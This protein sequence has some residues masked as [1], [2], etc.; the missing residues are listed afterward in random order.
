MTAITPLH[1]EISA[2][3]KKFLDALIRDGR[4]LNNLTKEAQG[5]GSVIESAFRKMAA[6]AGVSFG[7]AQ[8]K[9][10]AQEVINTRSQIQMLEQSFTVLLGSK[11]KADAMLVDIKEIALKSPL[12]LADTSSAA[13]TLLSFNIAAEKVIPTLRQLGDISMGNSDRFR[14]L[15][16]AFAQMSSAG[17]LM[18][19]DLLQMI[20]AGFNPLQVMSEKTGKSISALRDEMSKGV[21]SSEMVADAFRSATLEGGKFYNMMEKQAAGI[22]G[23]QASLGDAWMNMMNSLGEKSEGVIQEG[24]RMTTALVENYEKIGKVLVSLIATYGAY[25]AAMALN[26]IAAAKVTVAEAAHYAALVIVEKA[27]KA[28]N[29]AMKANPYVLLATVVVG[30]ASAM[31]ALH[32]GTTAEE[33]AQQRLNDELESSKQKKDSLISK[34]NELVSVINDETQTI[35]AQTRAWNDLKKTIPEAFAGMNIEDFKR[36]S[37]DEVKSRIN[38][39]LEKQDVAKLNEDIRLLEEWVSEYEKTYKTTRERITGMNDHVARLTNNSEAKANILYLKELNK[40]LERRNQL[41]REAEFDQKP[42]EEKLAILQ[43]QLA[44]LEEQRLELASTLPTEEKMSMVLRDAEGYTGGINEAWKSFDLKTQKTLGNIE[45][46]NRQIGETR[47][48]INSITGGDASEVVK[49]KEYWKKIKEEAESAR[50]ALDPDNKGTKAKWDELTK[51]IAGAT[52]Q[53]GKYNA[54]S[55]RNN[56]A[57]R[58]HAEEQRRLQ[59]IEDLREHARRQEIDGEM[60]LRQARI[61]VMK[62]GYEKELA[63]IDM[64]YD[65]RMAESARRADELIKQ[66]QE[67]ERKIWENTN[68]D[69]KERKLVFTPATT[70]V[71][72]LN[73]GLQK[74]MADEAKYAGEAKKKAEADLLKDLI[75]QYRD[76]ARQRDEIE[77]KFNEDLEFLNNKRTSD[78]ADE[79]DA[80][81]AQRTKEY[82]KALKGVRDVEFR[83]MQENSKLMQRLFGDASR[84]SQKQIR[85]VVDEARQLMEGT[86]FLQGQTPENIKAIY[87]ALIEKHDELDSRTNYPFASIMKGFKELEKAAEYAKKAQQEGISQAEADMYENLADSS[88]AKGLEY[89]KN[90]AIEASDMIASLTEKI[91]LLAEASGDSKFKE[92]ASQMS[93]LSK[94]IGAAAKGAQQGGW[95]GAII[96][97]VSDMISQTVEGIAVAKAEE[98]EFEQNAVDFNKEYRL[99]LLKLKDED[100]ESVFGVKTIDKTRKAYAL[101]QKALQ[102]YNDELAKR[103]TPE[104]EEE[105]SNLGLTGFG[106]G[107]LG[108][109]EWLGIAKTITNESKAML[110]AYKKGYTDLQAMAIK[111]K[112]RSG[113]QNFWGMKDQYTSLKDLAPDL[114]AND[115]GFN[116]DA[117]RIFL[118]TNTQITDEQ[119]KQIQ[120]IIDLKEA[121]DEAMAVIDE[122]AAEMMGSIATDIT[123]AIFDSVRNG[124]DAW[125]LFEDAGLK[126]I[127]TLGKELVKEMIIGEYLEQFRQRVRDAF[128]LEDSEKTQYELANI[129]TDIFNGMKTTMDAAE[130]VAKRWDENAK[131]MGWDVS[132]LK[133]ESTRQGAKGIA[134]S[135]TQDQATEMNGFLNNGLIFW[136]DI[137]NNTGLILAHLTAGGTNS[138]EL[139]RTY[140]QNMLA[141]VV[142]IDNNTGKLADIDK[143]ISDMNDSINEIKTRGVV[144]RKA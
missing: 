27:Q 127:D 133:E 125:D 21:I 142:N 119:R 36:L 26:V 13:Q 2:D 121:Y 126:V 16:L 137:S 56:D 62:D 113:W 95:I 118:E 50:D 4:A 59:E 1:Y 63:L 11:A 143:G 61:D 12:S 108:G 77:R 28:L 14:S 58:R 39:G 47:D 30:L 76:Y 67:I 42:A 40:E 111:T 130:M 102:E 109:F 85:A 66:Q 31:W 5:A 3:D 141:H 46:I 23:L 132:K 52:A 101:A 79:I 75:G 51:T 54:T 122:Y 64:A 41:E 114:W 129:V 7:V 15:T 96:G 107:A 29:L 45:S 73:A 53:L 98:K 55:E 105:Y 68:P 100:Y 43:K 90:G 112:D 115:G 144:L 139:L 86:D 65:K 74:Q 38:L 70:R 32:D 88:R 83:E 22:A 24:Y 84:M 134:A 128:S 91:N 8:I 34:T 71:E 19:Q 49:N 57:G 103:S 80:T 117:A 106:A 123:D 20:N 104:M 92:F 60:S 138:M 10:F 110:A 37:P 78:N 131:E 87:D 81:I 136:R 9:N 89:I 97:G 35:Y 18:G 69:W 33:K 140:G 94:N 6:V 120:N 17:K 25:R 72:D 48:K 135:M 116:V 82:Q 44:N 99:S 93:A 124:A